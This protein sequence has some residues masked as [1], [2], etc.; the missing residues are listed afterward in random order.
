MIIFKKIPKL[1]KIIKKIENL[2]KIDFYKTIEKI[3]K[4]GVSELKKNTPILTGETS[5]KW[6]Y[7]ISKKLYG[8]KISWTNSEMAGDIPLVVL[9]RYGHYTRNRGY[10]SPDDFI[11][12]SLMPVLKKI[13]SFVK[14]EIE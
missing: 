13:S 9:I 2:E 6:D 14:K 11:S 5:N 4:Y 8:Y 10:V 7:S 3:A 1:K 12:P